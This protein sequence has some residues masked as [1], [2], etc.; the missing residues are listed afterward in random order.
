[1]YDERG[2]CGYF[3]CLGGIVVLAFVVGITIFLFNFQVTNNAYDT[4]DH[5]NKQHI[6]EGKVVDSEPSGFM[7]D[8]TINVKDKKSDEVKQFSIKKDSNYQNNIKGNTAKFYY[9]DN[10]H[11]LYDLKEYGQP[12][13]GDEFEKHYDK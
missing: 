5:L 10:N 11:F 4:F 3:G 13:N 1:M 12:N 2:G 7:K 9:D 8:A 6:M